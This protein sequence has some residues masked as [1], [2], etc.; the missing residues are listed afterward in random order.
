VAEMKDS[1]GPTWLDR[2][3]HVED[4][5]SFCIRYKQ[6]YFPGSRMNEWMDGFWLVR[7]VGHRVVAVNWKFSR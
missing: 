7:N 1:A 6:V 4:K 3:R 5:E 2:L